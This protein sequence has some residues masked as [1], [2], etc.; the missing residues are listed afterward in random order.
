MLN[1]ILKE[2]DTYL[3]INK[4]YISFNNPGVSLVNLTPFSAI[5]QQPA[6]KRITAKYVYDSYKYHMILMSKI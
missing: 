1:Q 3:V 4:V 2:T 6:A 5:C